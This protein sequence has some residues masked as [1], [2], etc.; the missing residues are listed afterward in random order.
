[1][2]DETFKFKIELKMNIG[3]TLESLNGLI[4]KKQRKRISRHTKFMKQQ[5]R[6]LV[7]TLKQDKMYRQQLHNFQEDMFNSTITRINKK[8]KKKTK[9]L[10]LQNDTTVMMESDD[11][12]KSIPHSSPIRGSKNVTIVISKVV[13]DSSNTSDCSSQAGPSSKQI[14]E[15]KEYASSDSIE[16][17]MISNSKGEDEGNNW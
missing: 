8:T 6:T 3:K 12:F 9:F 10:D 4:N 15:R 2:I 5:K 11:S 16:S 14:E 13:I 1:M 7:K 17:K